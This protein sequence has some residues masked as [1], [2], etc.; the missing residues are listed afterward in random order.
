M[1][2]TRNPSYPTSNDYATGSATAAGT[3]TATGIGATAGETL[4][5]AMRDAQDTASRLGDRTAAA[6]EHMKANLGQAGE[7][8]SA[9][10]DDL[11]ALQEEWMAGARAYIQEHPLVA[12]AGA[13]AAG[14]LLARLLRD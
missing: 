14:M 5:R 6:T 2:T 8:L 3:G 7:A 4:D 13:L 9:G 12:V 10:L 11:N 1:S